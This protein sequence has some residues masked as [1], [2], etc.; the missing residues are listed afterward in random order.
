MRWYWLSMTK[1]MCMALKRLSPY[2]SSD[3]VHHWDF[4]CCPTSV[5]YCLRAS[6]KL[7]ESTMFNGGNVPPRLRNYKI[8]KANPQVA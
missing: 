5:S 4:T 7:L 8:F 1:G 6:P 2:P 3:R